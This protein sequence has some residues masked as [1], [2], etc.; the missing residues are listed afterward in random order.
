MRLLKEIYLDI[1]GRLG[2]DAVIGMKINGDDF[3][4]DGFVVEES[5]QVSQAMAHLGMDWIEV[6][7]GGIGEE[8]QYRER[9]KSGDPAFAE[10]SFA[11]HCEKIRATSKPKPVALVNGIRKL[12]TMQVIVDRGIADLISLS[13]P[14][15]REPDAIK[16]LQSGQSEVECIRC[17]AC[18]DLFE[19]EM[20]R[21][22]VVK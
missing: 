15:I 17:D 5:A 22:L 6:S 3:S 21:C 16:R 12:S 1:R 20:M 11:G 2:E 7:G 14:L 10:A 9:A 4:R 19:E 8:D 13:R 18:R